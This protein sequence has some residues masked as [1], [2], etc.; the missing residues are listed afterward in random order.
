MPTNLNMEAQIEWDKYLE[1]NTIE[2]QILHLE[3]FLGVVV[4]HKG[5]EN[6]LNTA[7]KKLKKLK[8]QL[9]KKAELEKKRG[10]GETWL[11]PKGDDGQLVL[12][13]MTNSG[14]STIL[15]VISDSEAA[16]IANYPFTTVRPKVSS[17]TAKGARLQ[18][19]ELPSLVKNSSR[20][21]MQGKLVLAGIRASDC[22][23]ITI[24]LAEDPIQQLELVLDEINKSKVRLNVDRPMVHIEKTGS[25]NIQVF[26]DHF[27]I[28]GDK[29]TITDL[30]RTSGYTNA[31]IRFYG[32]VKVN[33]LLDSLDRSVTYLSAVIFAT[34]GDLEGSKRNYKKLKDFIKTSGLK[35]PIY[36]VSQNHKESYEGLKE[37][38]FQALRRIRVYTKQPDGKVNQKPI[39]LE[40]EK[41]FVSDATRAVSKEFL[42]HFRFCRIWG[43]SANFD[44]EKVGLDHKLTDGD[45]VQIFA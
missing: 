37:Q 8:A 39:V 14:K 16:K 30:L 38:L 3:K 18:L 27:Y 35:F 13:G 21:E 1:A 43:K 15:N 12:C 7:K 32:E 2:D 5:V 9:E 42:K 31:I 25:G 40:S 11:V 23:I 45:I 28:D 34:K 10:G 24:N 29:E 41:C 20:G 17:I 26:N 19:V 33:Q 22:V 6:L 44:G 36:A 4:K